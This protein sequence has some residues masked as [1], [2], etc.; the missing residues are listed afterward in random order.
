[1]ILPP[2]PNREELQGLLDRLT[3]A[4]LPIDMPTIEL[5]LIVIL[6]VLLASPAAPTPPV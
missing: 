3:T 6:K 2:A 1:M 5:S 4:Q